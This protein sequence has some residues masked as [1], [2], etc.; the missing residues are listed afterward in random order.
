MERERAKCEERN[1]VIKVYGMKLL[2]NAVG[3]IVALNEKGLE[4]EYVPVDL[5]TGA[6]KNPE[7]HALIPFGR[8][9]LF[10]DDHKTLF[11]ACAT[12]RY[13]AQRYIYTG[14]N[15][16]PDENSDMYELLVA[17][18]KEFNSNIFEINFEIIGMTTNMVTVEKKVKY[19]SHLIAD[20]YEPHLAKNKYM[21]WDNFSFLDLYHMPD[22][23]LILK[24]PKADV[25]NSRLHVKAW[26]DDISARPAW[27]K[28]I[29]SFE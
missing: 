1:T 4:Y 8:I 19:L 16:V 11:D 3:V 2:N 23:Y 28:T 10:Q 9:P 6:H 18:F 12:I 24:T 17:Y 7:F 27:K 22:V 14:N 26:W 15:I 20:V 29:A 21:A 5:Y 25:I 13:I